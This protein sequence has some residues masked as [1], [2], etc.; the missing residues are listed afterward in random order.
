MCYSSGPLLVYS[1]SSSVEELTEHTESTC[2]KVLELVAMAKEVAKS[3][4]A[5]HISAQ[6]R[7]KLPEVEEVATK[8]NQIAK[9]QLLLCTG[10]HWVQLILPVQTTLYIHYTSVVV[11]Q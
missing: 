2:N 4:T 7:A 9:E 5:Q 10:K 11:T 1:T 6:I 8:F 3:S